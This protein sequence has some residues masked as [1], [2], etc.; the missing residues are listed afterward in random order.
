[1]KFRHTHL[2]VMNKGFTII[3][4]MISLAI[5][6][7]GVAAILTH[8]FTLKSV[9]DASRDAAIVEN[10]ANELIE[11]F[12][13]AR[14]EVLGTTSVVW[15]VHRPYTILAVGNPLTDTN[16]GS[17]NSLVTI[18][19]LKQPTGMKDLRVYID[20]YRAMSEVDT[21]GLPI[22]GQ[23]G[24]M[25]GEDVTYISLS[26]LKAIWRDE[27]SLLPY[28][29]DPSINPTTQVSENRPVLIRILITSADLVRPL[30]FFTGRKA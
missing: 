20:Y 12:S 21:A 11:R 4:V 27:T 26:G 14:W 3:E 23:M 24:L 9:R 30:V 13:G 1:M 6:A 10:V 28:R 2:Q 15:S 29:L 8:M 5:L 25:D 7:V 17:I 19:V 16:D 22:P 18:G